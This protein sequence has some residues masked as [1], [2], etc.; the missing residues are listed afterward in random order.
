MGQE[1]PHR[2]VAAADRVLSRAVASLQCGLCAR[3]RHGAS[4]RHLRL[5]HSDLVLFLR[6]HP[7]AQNYLARWEKRHDKGQALTGLAHKLA[8][9]V[10]DRLK[11]HLAFDQE[12]CVQR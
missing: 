1:P 12:Q 5:L 11:R 6:D 3:W 9:A 10:Y 8:R 7:P 4:C 2:P